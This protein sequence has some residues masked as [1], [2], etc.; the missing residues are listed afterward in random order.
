M[1]KGDLYYFIALQLGFWQRIICFIVLCNVV[2]V[3]LWGGNIRKSVLVQSIIQYLTTRLRSIPSYIRSGGLLEILIPTLLFLFSTY[4]DELLYRMR[5]DSA[6]A[7]TE[8]YSQ[9]R[10]AR[11]SF[12]ALVQLQCGGSYTNVQSTVGSSLI[13]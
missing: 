5:D 6:H 9:K 7:L 8:Q 1:G 3:C 10:R 12:R 4:V 13:R 2:Y 11:Y